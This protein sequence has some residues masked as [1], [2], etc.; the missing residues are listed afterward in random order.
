MNPLRSVFLAVS[1]WPAQAAG[2]PSDHAEKMARGCELF[3]QDVRQ[4]LH[5]HCVKC[6][7]GEKTRSDF[8]L[9]TREG[10]LR[11]GKEGIV[12]R[13]FAAAESRL[14]KLVRHVE[15]P[16]MPDQQPKLPDADIAK[17]AAWIDLGA[18]YDEPLVA[19]KPPPRD[20][21]AVTDANRQWWSFQTIRTVAPPK[22]AANPVDAFLLR[23]AAG[24]RL[25]LNPSAE[26]RQLLR[27]ACLDVTGLPP[28]PEASEAF[29]TDPSPDA[30]PR[31]IARLLDSPA[32]GERWA[33]HWL[34][35]ARFAESSGFEHDYD[36][37]NAFHYRD[38][39]IRALNEDLSFAQFVCWQL[40][41]D[42][43]APGDP[44]ALAATGFL[45]A[46]VFPTQITANEVERTRYDALDDMLA[47]TSSAFLGLTVGCARCHDHKFDP[48]PTRDYYRLLST[49]TSTVRSNVELDLDP[50]A[51]ARAQAKFGAEQRRLADELMAFENR[52]LR[53]K[54][55]LW[56]GKSA[57]DLPSSVW[58]VLDVS[59]IVS[60][61]GATFKKLPDDSWLA[62]GKN[63]AS[64]VYTIIATTLRRGLTGL[65]LE[66]LT[67]ASAP[68]HGPGRADNGN[69]ALSRIR[70]QAEPLTGGAV[71]DVKLVGTEAT[72]EQN[73]TS[74]SAASSLDDDPKSGWAVDGGGIGKDQAASFTF[75]EPLDFVQ[76]VKLTISL[77]FSVNTG[78]TIARP[79]LS[80][81]ADG[82][83]R[84]QDA[85]LP[86][87]VAALIPAL[88]SGLALTTDEAEALF[89]WWKRSDRIWTERQGKFA[90]HA[91]NAP[92]TKTPVL[93]CAEGYPPLV[94]HS[95]GPPFLPATHI[96]QRG[97]PNQKKDV[98]QPGFL[99]VLMRGAD[100]KEWQWS[101]P[102]GASY[103]GR[104]R[105][106][107]NWLTDPVH[108]AGGL[109]ARVAVNRLW[110]HHFGRGLVATP[111]DFGQMGAR[112]SNPELLDW[113]AGELIR[114]GWHLKPIHQLLMTSAAY[115][116]STSIDPAKLAADPDNILWLRRVPQRLEAEAIRDSV[117]AV[118]GALDGTMFGPGTLDER[119]RRRSIY[120]TIKRS[121]LVNSMVVFDAPEP[122]T[123]QGFRPTTTV[124]PQALLMMNG[125]QTREWALA[126]ARRAEVGLPTADVDFAPQIAR[127]YALALGRS[128]SPEES[129]AAAAFIR[130]G[131][132]AYASSGK[133]EA[134]TLALADFCQTTLALNEF[135][136]VD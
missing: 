21:S 136:Y 54:F 15:E 24:R 19:G 69:F 84:L 90:E 58:S 132:T 62:E 101:P 10:L 119:S 44:W 26:R 55:A 105:T 3:R 35:V 122:L 42:E 13:P 48:I 110:Q 82:K 123:S 49:F 92:S 5:Q 36:R 128:P 131:V 125:A 17:I 23:A 115:Q 130:R 12:L 67:D 52:E 134:R 133:T 32:Y 18:P 71:R 33:R 95:Q 98:A 25:R 27:R 103:S 37:P 76:G 81:F 39:V 14:L 118:S 65:K 135:I 89:N 8:D 43:F 88:R 53:P 60:A 73:Q 129:A 85:V 99:Q 34:D 68:H 63:G 2:L 126:F 45:G 22:G 31:L 66:A 6:H 93:I 59:G 104:R 106:L 127:I 96:L 28:S 120:F 4:L 47:T 109:L 94:M 30:W 16:E 78:H 79:R 117:L 112:P 50:A 61:A 1:L 64:D 77:E 108:G 20:R 102:A 51:S 83:P 9:T 87:A 29:L 11:G 74:L 86:R 72:H 97:D 91:K 75:A 124:A 38:F 41:G 107:A 114:N 113:L 80:V 100:E 56:R 7:G 46:G 111:N 70:V 121:R 116:Q 57:P 40:A